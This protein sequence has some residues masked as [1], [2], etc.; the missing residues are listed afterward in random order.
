MFV[1]ILVRMVSCPAPVLFGTG[2]SLNAHVF[3]DQIF[4]VR[5]PRKVCKRALIQQVKA[6]TDHL[7]KLLKGDHNFIA[8]GIGAAVVDIQAAFIGMFGYQYFEDE[9]TVPT[10]N[11][12][13]CVVN[14]A[15]MTYTLPEVT[16][17]NHVA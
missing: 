16:A 5:F 3:V 2:G 8:L 12:V 9:F 17:G 14:I 6:V 10:R 11:R 15:R 13:H 1:F 4:L 7:K